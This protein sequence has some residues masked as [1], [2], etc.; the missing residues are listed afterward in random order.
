MPS[1]VGPP[2]HPLHLHVHHFQ[3][4]EHA[5]KNTY[6][7]EANTG[8]YLD[9]AISPE[10]EFGGGEYKLRFMPTHFAG[11]VTAH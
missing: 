6:G 7:F 5:V 3:V 1:A 9:V 8:D 10:P 4:V 2:A 11:A